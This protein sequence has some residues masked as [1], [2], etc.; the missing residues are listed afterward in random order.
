[1]P[2]FDTADGQR[3]YFESQGSGAQTI[4]FIHGSFLS[5]RVWD[6]Q[7]QLL[8][9]TH[10][11]LQ[12]DVRGHGRSD[13]PDSGY[14]YEKYGRDVAELV[15]HLSLDSV[16]VIGWSMGA[17][18][19]VEFIEDNLSN[20]AKLGLVSSG[21]F[22]RI[23]ETEERDHEYIPYEKFITQLQTRRPA[24]MDWFIDSI[25]GERL[26]EPTRRWLWN[27]AMESAIQANVETMEAA[28]NIKPPRLRSILDEVDVP[29]GIFHGELDRAASTEEAR[30]VSEQ[31]VADGDLFTYEESRHCAFLSEPNA[32]NR[33]L[34]AFI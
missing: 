23:S 30:Y 2:Y 7:A 29:V 9:D 11:V 13:A 33:D 4:L 34:E 22:H 25:T 19:A 5:G 31:L 3:L 17:I 28:A 32:F 20:V 1:M 24:A 27:I 18:V 12:I 14:T 8:A 10:R 16:I 6:H 21:M 15:D 26:G